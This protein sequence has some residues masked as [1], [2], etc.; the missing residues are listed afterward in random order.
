M[1]PFERGLRSHQSRQ[2]IFCGEII[3]AYHFLQHSQH[4]NHRS[5]VRENLCKQRS[6]Y[7]ITTPK[8]ITTAIPALWNAYRCDFT[9]I[10]ACGLAEPL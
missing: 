5:I 10:I 8:Q 4:Q 7:E 2:E 1:P 9:K 3:S 6:D